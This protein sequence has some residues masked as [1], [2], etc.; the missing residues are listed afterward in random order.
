MPQNNINS[1]SVIQ[2]L[3]KYF[4]AGIAT[5]FPLFITIYIFVIIF[6]LTN[7]LLGH[8]INEYLKTTYGFV[9]PGL[10]LLTL[11]LVIIIIGF[12]ANI[13]VGQK[14]FPWV[15]RV[16]SK[17]PIVE[18]VFIPLKKLSDYLFTKSSKQHLKKV[19]LVEYPQEDS[20]SIGF[21]TSD[22]LSKFDQEKGKDLVCVFI[23]LVPV[24]MSGFL[25]ILPKHKVKELDISID[26]SIEFIVS[27]GV[28]TPS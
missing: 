15:E 28:I 12:I 16:F 9:I 21:I 10:G 24:P 3:K 6:Q 19:V 14:F 2:N 4:I 27:G 20:Y 13:F 1:S 7:Q 18:K 26:Q 5:L 17:T 22:D 23:P 11:L 8:H 25:I